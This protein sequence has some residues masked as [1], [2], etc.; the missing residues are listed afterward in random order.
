MDLSKAGQTGVLR[1]VFDEFWVKNFELVMRIV[2]T[3][4]VSNMC[5]ENCFCSLHTKSYDFDSQLW[6]A[7][8][9]CDMHP[10]FV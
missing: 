2:P 7:A 1:S 6:A 5:K 8:H 9:I 3:P 4:M 10:S